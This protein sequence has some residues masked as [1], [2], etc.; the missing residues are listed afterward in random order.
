[1]NPY[2][3]ARVLV[4]VI[5]LASLSA[6]AADTGVADRM[7]QYVDQ[8]EIA[9]AVTLVATRDKVL[10]VQAV[11]MADLDKQEPMRPDAIFWIASMTKPITAT[12]VMMLQDEGKL[13]VED[14]ASK[15]IPEL[16]NL[17]T[18]DGKPANVTL[19]HMLTHTSGM[20]EA[21]SAQMRA[22][23]ALADLVPVYAAQ[24][25]KFTP[26]SKWEYCQSGINSLGRIVEIVSG[27]N[28][29]DFFQARLFRPLGMKDTTFY[30]TESQ[31]ARIARSYSRT[32][33]GKLEAVPV[34]IL[35][36]HAASDRGR[37]PAANGGLFS[38]AA[39]YGRFCRMI[40]SGGSLDGRQYLKPETV[41]QMTSVQTPPGITTGFTPGNGWGLGWCVVKDPQGVTAKLSPGTHGHGGAFGTQ[42]WI[43]PQ[44]GMIYVLM[45]QRANFPNSDASD[46]RKSFHEAASALAR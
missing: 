36:G 18:K 19:R 11:G 20:G 2:R 39:D 32:G 23:K 13:S 9:G 8:K 29:E 26:G 35:E 15:Y 3:P 21:T 4:G 34:F 16:A 10:D 42:A 28:L 41:K 30:P 6:A 24:P 12:A 31:V 33:A 17:K 46:V 14:P 38:T 37:Y 45:T 22:A 1:M 40:L 43:D 44:K 27:Q 7:R 25:V 5:A